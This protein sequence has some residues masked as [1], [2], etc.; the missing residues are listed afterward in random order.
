F[1]NMLKR[2][3]AIQQSIHIPLIVK[4]VG[5]GMSMETVK[6]L[7]E[8]GVSIVDVG[9]YGGTNF[10]QIE[11]AR[12]ENP[13]EF[14]NEWGIPTAISIIEA[15]A[16][17]PKIN[18]IASGGIQSSVEIVKALSLGASSAALAGKFLRILM[19]NNI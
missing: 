16:A 10:A 4:E 12:R 14:F 9:G 15:R 19:K 13:F 1:T 17:A 2:M 11:N 7:K 3:E 8:I 5:F 6:Q 18:I